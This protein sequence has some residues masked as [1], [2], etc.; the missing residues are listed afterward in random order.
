MSSAF[1]VTIEGPGEFVEAAIKS[2]RELGVVDSETRGEGSLEASG[3]GIQQD[4]MD[5]WVDEAIQVPAVGSRFI[6]ARI[7]DEGYWAS[8]SKMS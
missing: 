4:Q 5:A 8:R 3:Y 6:E 7:P 2:L 1:K